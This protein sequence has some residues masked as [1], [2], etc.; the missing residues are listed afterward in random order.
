MSEKRPALGES[1]HNQAHV[2]VQLA[3][4]AEEKGL[5]T[6]ILRAST[7]AAPGARAMFDIDLVTESRNQR[8]NDSAPGQQR[9]EPREPAV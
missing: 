8:V 9:E 1:W 3:L 6:A 2:R 4:P 7:L 5:H